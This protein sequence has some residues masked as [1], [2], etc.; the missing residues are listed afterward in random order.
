[1][2]AERLERSVLLLITITYLLAKLKMPDYFEIK[3]SSELGRY[4]TVTKNVLAGDVIFEEY[5]F[6]V[7]PKP[8]VPPVCLVCCYPV[9]GSENGPRCSYCRW[10]LCENCINHE[11]HVE[12][13][14]LFVQNNVQFHNFASNEEACTQLDCITPL[15]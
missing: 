9:D 8:N 7:G 2:S 15:R 11:F 4:T 10:P 3:E 12:E 14:K 5:P 1:M 13:C 6:V